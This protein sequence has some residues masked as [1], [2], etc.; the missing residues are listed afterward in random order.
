MPRHVAAGCGEKTL[1]LGV[2]ECAGC[3]VGVTSRWEPTAAIGPGNPTT[4]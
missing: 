2:G 4:S 1:S 3:C